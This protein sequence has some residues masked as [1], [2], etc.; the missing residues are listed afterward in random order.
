MI[1]TWLADVRPLYKESCYRHYYER[2]PKF[3]KEKADRLRQQ[4]NKAQSAGAWLLL[5]EIRTRH[6][7][8]DSAVYNFSH[9]EDYVLCSVDTEGRTGIQVGCDIEKI[10]EDRI[11]LARHFFCRSE[12]EDLLKSRT[13]EERIEKFYRYWV[14]KESFMKATR[15]GMRLPLS[16]F[17]IQLSDPP[18]LKRKPEQFPDQYYYREYPLDGFPYRVAVCSNCPDIDS[19]I[20]MEL[21]QIWQE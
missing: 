1:D 13:T 15:E 11:N 3:R 20:Q 16:A 7:I 9:S 8:S 4:Q 19:K 2:L 10:R 17:E 14:L 5:E 18:L 21:T 12:Y 6:K